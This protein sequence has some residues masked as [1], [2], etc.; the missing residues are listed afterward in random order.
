MR[1]ARRELTRNPESQS[2]D[3][4]LFIRRG[5]PCAKIVREN[6]AASRVECSP[7]WGLFTPVAHSEMMGLPRSLSSLKKGLDMRLGHRSGVVR[8]F[9]PKNCYRMTIAVA[10]LGLLA[11]ELALAGGPDNALLIV[12]PARPESM[13]VANYYQNVRNIPAQNIVYMNPLATNFATFADINAKAVFGVLDNRRLRD[14]ADF[15][16]ATSPGNF[17]IPATGTIA[18]SCSPVNR[19]SVNGAYTNCF[20]TVEILGGINSTY[21]NRYSST[22][23]TPVAFDSSN[24]WISGNPGSGTNARRYFLGAC[25]GYTGLRGNTLAE[26]LA[27]IDRS[28]AVDGTRP[29][30]TFY[31]EQ[32]TDALRSGPRH[33]AF[34]AA[35][36]AIIGFGGNAEHQMAILPIGRHD[37]LGIMTGWADPG[38]LAA[39]MTILPGAFC[40][41]LTSY[42]GTFDIDSQEKISAWISKGASGS[43]GTVEEPCNYAGKFPHARMHVF[44]F[45]GL[46]LGEACFRSVGYAPIQGLLYGDPLTRPFAHIPAV[47][48][49]GVPSSPASGLVQLTP[50]AT[51]THPTAAIASFDLLVD[52][53]LV[54]SVMPGG[55]LLLGTPSLSDG[56]HELRALAYDNTPVKSVGRWIGAITVN[57]RGRS[58]SISADVASGDLD[59]AFQL[60]LASVGVGVREIRLVQNDRVLAASAGNAAVFSVYGNSLGAGTTKLHAEALFEAG[61]AVRSAP[62]TLQI[63]YAGGSSNGLAPVSTNYVKRVK[64]GANALIELPAIYR[65]DPGTL[66]FTV[67]SPPAQAA[68]PAG[69]SGAARV[70]T[71]NPTAAGNDTM[72]YRIDSPNGASTTSTITLEYYPCVGDLDENEVIDVADLAILLSNFGSGVLYP[73]L[74]GD[75]DGDGIVTLGDLSL[76]LSQFGANC[77]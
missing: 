52:G 8:N 64:R 42:A 46:T 25:L 72:T 17:Y 68:V 69:Q 65:A 49:A 60:T 53:K 21:L 35:V 73:F 44:Y 38:V 7:N 77:P 3:S 50:S 5:R 70:I 41:H 56:W 51:T 39:D 34:P 66:S 48:L 58:A 59:T 31:Y 26:I 29:T 67:V 36:S 47:N 10:A 20:N 45:Q 15:L 74:D 54:D 4:A 11:G 63:A 13:Y 71:P 33:G 28:A 23:N 18:D 55:V 14:H 57:N 76:L 27:M 61:H 40:D 43:W 1:R 62:L 22:G 75:V 32:T 2:E 19:F 6:C 30:G 16:I 24:G 37:C 12:D 9:G